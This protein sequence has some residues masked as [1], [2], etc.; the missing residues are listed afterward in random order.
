ML[1]SASFPVLSH[2][3]FIWCH[4]TQV[5]LIKTPHCASHSPPA[6]STLFSPSLL[7]PFAVASSHAHLS[8]IVPRVRLLP[9]LLPRNVPLLKSPTTGGQW[10]V[11]IVLGCWT[12]LT[13][14]CQSFWNEFS[15]DFLDLILLLHH[16]MPVPGFDYCF[17]SRF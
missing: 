8:V 12:A 5:F 10:S 16:E 14:I 6:T 9:S 17:V 4:H 15:L 1:T 13:I 11:L 3:H 2:Q 7:N